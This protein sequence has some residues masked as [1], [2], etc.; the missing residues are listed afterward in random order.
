MNSLL[1]DH[2]LHGRRKLI[3]ERNPSADQGQA[4]PAADNFPNDQ[5]SAA[6]ERR[7]G[8]PGAPFRKLQHPA[9]NRRPAV[10]DPVGLPA[11]DTA[12]PTAA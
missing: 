11:S 5:A 12:E 9:A 10:S 2:A 7:H 1:T 8:A 3:P 4:P 6:E